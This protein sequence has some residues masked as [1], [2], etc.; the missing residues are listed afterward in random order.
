MKIAAI[1]TI[2]LKTRN[3]IM[4]LEKNYNKILIKP[5]QLI[6]KIKIKTV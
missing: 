3:L 2:S 4:L 1:N 5:I 6:L